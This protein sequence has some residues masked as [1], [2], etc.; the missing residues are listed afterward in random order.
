MIEKEFNE[1]GIRMSIGYRQELEQMCNLSENIEKKGR[2]LEL[3]ELVQ[4]GLLPIE[5]AAGRTG[6][7]LVEFEEEMNLFLVNAHAC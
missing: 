2:M 4:E 6:Q 3:F 5:T 7:S 1:D